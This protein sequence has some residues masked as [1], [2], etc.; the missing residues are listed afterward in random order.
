MVF[1]IVAPPDPQGSI[2]NLH[3][4]RKYSCK[5]DTFWFSGSGEKEN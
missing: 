1:L 2:L 5:Y 4:I 3:Y